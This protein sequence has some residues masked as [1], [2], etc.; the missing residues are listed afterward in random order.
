[1][2]LNRNDRSAWRAAHSSSSG[3]S[4]TRSITAGSSC[5][6]SQFWPRCRSSS[7]PI[8]A[9]A[10]VE[11]CTPLVIDRIGS[12]STGD[13]GPDRL[14]HL[15]GHLAVQTADAVDGAA[16]AHRE[17]RHVEHRAAAAVVVAERE[18]LL[19][20][21]TE[22]TPGACQ[23]G[24]DQVKRKR[25]VSRGHRRVRGEDRG[26]TNFVQ[27]LSKF[28][29]ASH[30]S[31]MRCST[32][33]AGVPFVQVIDRGLVAHGL[34]HAHAANAKNDLL[35]HA[36]LAIATVQARREV[37]VPWRVLLEVGIEQVEHERARRGRAKPRRGPSGCRAA[38]P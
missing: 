29:P 12:F 7:A 30:R 32:T 35:L 27:R 20:V 33:K 1:M 5:E 13:T 19:A 23:M 9:D 14:P 25:I 37:A 10:H 22:V 6:S 2:K 8:S 21:S 11:T 3:M 38:L 15:L 16:G 26:A 18:K 17:R 4:I 28:A 36:R 24:L 31:R 34:Q